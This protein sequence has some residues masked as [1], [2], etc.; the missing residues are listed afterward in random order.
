MHSIQVINSTFLIAR[1]VPTTLVRGKMEG[2]AR[3]RIAGQ[4]DWK[5]VW[6]SVSAGS[7][8]A[9][10]GP[11]ATLANAEPTPTM[12]GKRLSNFFSR[13]NP[14][15][16]GLV[17]PP[18]PIITMYTS[19]KPKDRKKPL[20]TL[21]NVTQAFGV[22]PERPDLINKSTLMKIEG[23]FGDEEMGGTVKGKEGW[24]LIMPELNESSVGPGG[25][26]EKS[27]AAEM[28]KW[29]VGALSRKSTY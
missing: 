20:L 8:G 27:Q 12:K 9:H 11:S 18:R 6:L 23:T 4:T 3:V 29:I 19:P 21:F 5:K 15:N 24:V 25:V 2:W 17:L 10:G 14:G 26:G 22:Y 1:D 16:I 28:L 13:D 7:E